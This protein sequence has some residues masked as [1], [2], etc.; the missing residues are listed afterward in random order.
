MRFVR[1]FLAIP[2]IF[3]IDTV[4]TTGAVSP[5]IWDPFF[6]VETSVFKQKT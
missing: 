1:L 5:V 6:R 2:L 4:R 3:R